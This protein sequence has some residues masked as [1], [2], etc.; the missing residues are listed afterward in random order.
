MITQGRAIEILMDNLG[1][2]AVVKAV[3]ERDNGYLFLAERP[4]PLEGRF[5]PFFKVDKESGAFID[6]SPQDYENPREILDPMIAQAEQAG[7]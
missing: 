7:F 5:D 3:I 1:P 4:D 6:F 2:S